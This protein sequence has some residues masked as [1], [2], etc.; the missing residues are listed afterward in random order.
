MALPTD[1][2]NVSKDEKVRFPDE[3][4]IW[5][6]IILGN[7]SKGHWYTADFAHGRLSLE[8]C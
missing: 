4:G 1:H 5:R 2:S 6:C 3:L 8:L 7:T